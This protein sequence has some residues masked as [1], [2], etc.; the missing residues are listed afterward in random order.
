VH[1][2]GAGAANHG[3]DGTGQRRLPEKLVAAVAVLRD[4]SWRALPCQHNGKHQTRS[5]PSLCLCAHAT[6]GNKFDATGDGQR[7]R[8]TP[9]D[10][11][12]SSVSRV[13]RSKLPWHVSPPVYVTT[14]LPLMILGELVA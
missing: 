2:K 6:H 11:L 1:L 12:H 5:K 3:L 14:M 13:D 10:G 4:V 8:T 9:A 7:S